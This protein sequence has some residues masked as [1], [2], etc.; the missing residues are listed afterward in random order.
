[1]ARLLASGFAL[2]FAIAAS[3]GPIFFLC[4][5]RTLA[6]GWLHGLVSGLGVAS[7][8]AT[9]GLVAALGLTA[10]SAFL[11]GQRLWLELA[12]GAAL[13]VLAARM[14]RSRPAERPA[15][16]ARSGEGLPA[17]YLSIFGLTIAN[18]QTI[19]SFAAVFAGLGLDL[20]SGY[21]PA[22]ALVAGVLLG[23]ASWWLVLTG[24]V[25]LLRRRIAGGLLAGVTLASGLAVGAF[26]VAAV[27]SALL[28][29]RGGR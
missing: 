4:V 15:G 26:G 22:A 27:V 28:A 25:A 14:L 2:G 8:D 13:L 10:V 18:P 21:A 9:Y 24:S 20:A 16:P 1:M 3:P 29:M 23:S 6:R 17:A 5:R 19:L 12:G 11:T 7:A